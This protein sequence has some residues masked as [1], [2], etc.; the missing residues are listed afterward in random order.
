MTAVKQLVTDLLRLKT[1]G[2]RRLC[3]TAGVQIARP[4]ELEEG[5]YYVAC[6]WDTFRYV[7]YRIRMPPM[8]VAVCGC[9][10]LCVVVCS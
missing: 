10:W 7:D 4:E 2:V 3:T 1:S 5:A 6:G 8:C 9:V